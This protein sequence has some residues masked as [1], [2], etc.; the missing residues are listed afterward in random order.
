M[1]QQIVQDVWSSESNLSF[2]AKLKECSNILSVWGQQVTRSFKQRINQSKGIIRK[3]KRHLDTLSSVLLQVEKKKL[4]EIYVQQE[5]FW[6]QRSKQFWLHEGDQNSKYF[7]AARKNRRKA[8]RICS[9]Q[10][11]ISASAEGVS[12]LNEVMVKYFVGLF[13]ASNTEWEAVTDCMTTKISI[14]QNEE[15]LA[16]VKEVEV[17][18]A[19]FSMHPDKSPGPDGMSPGFY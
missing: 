6:R 13:S 12:G 17:K 15:M 1:C 4:K 5:I 18:N 14:V 16:A 3:L 19:L 7:H 10:D 8:N 9:L 2:Y 11:T